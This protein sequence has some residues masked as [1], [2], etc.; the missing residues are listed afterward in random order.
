MTKISPDYVELLPLL[1]EIFDNCYIPENKKKDVLIQVC[2]INTMY[3]S[4]TYSYD[5]CHSLKCHIY[6]SVFFFWGGAWV[7]IFFN[8]ILRLGF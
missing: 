3:I 8:H 7:R 6:V 2:K 1:E 4:D 5:K